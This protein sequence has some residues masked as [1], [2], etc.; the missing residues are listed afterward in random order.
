M[1]YTMAV[2]IIFLALSLKSFFCRKSFFAAAD[3]KGCKNI[4]R[5]LDY[6]HRHPWARARKYLL[7]WGERNENA[8]F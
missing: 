2:R 3:N 6:C 8:N 5:E 7:A 4:L 1:L